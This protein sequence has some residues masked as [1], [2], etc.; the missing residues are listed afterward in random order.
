ML[1]VA[2]P[3]FSALLDSDMREN[4]EGTIRLEHMTETVM[5]DIL[6][7]M[8]SGKTEVTQTNAQDLIEAADYLFLPNLKIFAGRFMKENLTISN[9]IL[10]YYFAEKYRCDEL[11]VNVREFILSNFALVAESRDFLDLESQQVEKWISCDAIVVA[12]EV[13]VFEIILKWIKE[14]KSERKGKLAELFRHVRLAFVT[15]DFLK[16]DV[17]TNELVKESPR[18]LKLVSDA[19]KFIYQNTDRA[20]PMPPRIYWKHTHLVVLVNSDLTLCY[21]PDR[22]EWYRLKRGGNFFR[23]NYN[24]TT[25]QGRLYYSSFGD[26]CVAK[27]YDPFLNFWSSLDWKSS[28]LDVIY[29]TTLTVVGGIM[30]AVVEQSHERSKISVKSKLIKYDNKSN[31]WNPV[32]TFVYEGCSG[33]YGACAV[34][35]DNYL[36]LIGGRRGNDF[37]ATAMQTAGR[38]NITEMKWEKIANIQQARWL[39]CGVAARGKIFIA[40]GW[41]YYDRPSFLATEK[42][43]VYN[44]L[45]NEWHFIASL[46]K[47]RA[48]GSMVCFEG[49][50]YL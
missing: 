12:T 11:V 17:M 37:E 19:L 5:R 46:N 22:K 34:A 20:S 9:C 16:R 14:D 47:L 40:G 26:P 38:F 45:T 44:S 15:R 3:F 50:L 8:Q 10:M 48:R 36:Y 23:E 35:M 32:L 33:T 49:T 28:A 29:M 13:E 43:E 2:S 18:C 31:S 30:Y 1:S 24:L 6:E 39:A 7:F 21:D 27:Q 4:R 41:I 42:C 25:F